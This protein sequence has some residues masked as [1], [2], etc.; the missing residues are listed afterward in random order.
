MALITI[1]DLPQSIELDRKAMLATVGGARAGVRTT[2][3]E[4]ATLRS[5]RIVDYPPGFDR[6]R[7]TAANGQRLVP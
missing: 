3:L 2:G 6:D 7:L 5:G 1:K 4:A